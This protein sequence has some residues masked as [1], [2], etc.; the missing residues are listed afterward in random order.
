MKKV[1]KLVKSRSPSSSS[2]K[3]GFGSRSPSRGSLGQGS[4]SFGGESA[5]ATSMIYESQ[6][7]PRNG[8]TPHSKTNPEL[9][10]SPTKSSNEKRSQNENLPQVRYL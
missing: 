8:G 6:K 4:S 10:A 2:A 1:L 7:N 9:P 5:S 3:K